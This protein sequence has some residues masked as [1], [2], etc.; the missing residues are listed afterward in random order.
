MKINPFFPGAEKGVKKES[1]QE[2]DTLFCLLLL[3]LPLEI[4][5]GSFVQRNDGHKLPFSSSP[6]SLAKCNAAKMRQVVFRVYYSPEVRRSAMAKIS[7][8][9]E[10]KLLICAGL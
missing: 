6:L 9:V 8:A 10:Q 7:P 4:K 1:G 3:L 5:K 2:N